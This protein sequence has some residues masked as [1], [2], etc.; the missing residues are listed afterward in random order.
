MND[1]D[2]INVQQAL[3]TVAQMLRD[4]ADLTFDA[5]ETLGTPIEMIGC[6]DTAA[7]AGKVYENLRVEDITGSQA[8]LRFDFG[9]NQN[10]AVFINEGAGEVQLANTGIFTQHNYSIHGQYALSPSTAYTITLRTDGQPDCEITFVTTDS[11]VNSFN[12]FELPGGNYSQNRTDKGNSETLVTFTPL[13]SNGIN[14]REILDPN[15]R[16]FWF[17]YELFIPTN[18][19][20]T[21]NVKIPGFAAAVTGGPGTGI[22][23]QGGGGSGGSLAWSNRMLLHRRGTSFQELALGWEMYHDASTNAPFGQTIWWGNNGANSGSP[24]AEAALNDGQ[25]NKIKQYIKLNTPGQNDGEVR[26]WVNGSLQSIVTNIGFSDD[27]TTT[28]GD[29]DALEASIWMNFFIGGSA[30]TSGNSN[31][32]CVRNERYVSGPNDLL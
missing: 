6:I 22:G 15:E 8:W 29:P 5:S 14:P 27:D 28:D 32:V 10:I 7:P 31:T 18:F 25:W 19:N 17:C 30:D 23:G 21:S 11:Q 12:T 3:Q 9:L 26:G 1:V 2:R 24:T 16:E 20:P 13:S 4:A